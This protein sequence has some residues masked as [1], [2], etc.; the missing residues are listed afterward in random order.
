MPTTSAQIDA[1]LA[2]SKTIAVVGL[3]ARPERASYEV[4]EYLQAQGYRIIPVNP[5]AAGSRILGEHCY[6]SLSEAAGEHAIDIVDC[7]R[8]AE[9]IPPLVDE[10]IAIKAPCIWMQL[11]ISHPAAARKAE[12]AGL[13]VVMDKCTKTEHRLRF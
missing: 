1:L 9:D 2:R 3:S 13:Q 6:A 10:A 4:A 8:K 12:L 11:G 5:A 7:F